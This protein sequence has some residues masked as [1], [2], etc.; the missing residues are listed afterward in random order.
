MDRRRFVISSYDFQNTLTYTFVA[1]CFLYVSMCV[2]RNYYLFG[3]SFYA[4]LK[5]L[6]CFDLSVRL[7]VWQWLLS[8]RWW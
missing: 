6:I 1:L 8:F 2:S 7:I 3:P 5:K 4:V